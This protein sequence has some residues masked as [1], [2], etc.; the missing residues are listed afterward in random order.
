MAE[1]LNKVVTVLIGILIALG[2]WTLSRT[3]ELSTAQA[4]HQEKLAKLESNIEKVLAKDKEMQEQHAKL[5]E[6]LQANPS[7]KMDNSGYN[8]GNRTGR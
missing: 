5:F 6:M 2:T 4:I 7:H 1:I 3:F 8:Y